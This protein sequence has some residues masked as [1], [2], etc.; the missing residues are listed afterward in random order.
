M[1][2]LGYLA[3]VVIVVW[4]AI[5]AARYA[6][7]L[8]RN[9]KVAGAFIGAVILAVVTSM[10]E[11]FTSISAVTI[12]DMPDFPAGNILGSNIFNLVVVSIA[13]LIYRKKFTKAKISGIYSRIGIILLMI[14]ALVAAVFADIITMRIGHSSIMSPIIIIIYIITAKYISIAHDDTAD[15]SALKYIASVDCPLETKQ[16]MKRLLITGVFLVVA[17]AAMTYTAG[18]ITIEW[19]IE[20]GFGGAIFLGIATSVPELTSLITLFR[21]RNYDVA[22]GSMVGSNLFNFSI[23]AIADIICREDMY[24]VG[25]AKTPVMVITGI[26]TTGLFLFMLMERK[27]SKKIEVACP[28]LILACYGAFFFI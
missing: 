26:I 19:G 15:E 18:L 25:Q 9:S 4:L 23:L 10:P 6:N 14:Y 24:L 1:I 22:I 27:H 13:I 17:S 2:Y 20:G 3:S 16:A 7:M 11:F 8:D 28:L 5:N 12:F 21:V